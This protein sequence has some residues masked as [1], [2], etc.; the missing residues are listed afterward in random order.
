ML[1]REQNLLVDHGRFP[2]KLIELLQQCV[3]HSREESPLYS[4]SVGWSDLGRFSALL[5]IVPEDS[6]T[7]RPASATLSITESTSLRQ[8]VHL[9]LKLNP[10]SEQILKRHLTDVIC[11]YRVPTGDPVPNAVRRKSVV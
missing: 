10:V 1:R 4:Q 7:S 6:S 5:Q 2:Y 9:S 8:I 11:H 3:A